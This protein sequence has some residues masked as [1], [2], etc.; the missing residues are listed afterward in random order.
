MKNREVSFQWKPA[1]MQR[2]G[3]SL[4][5][6]LAGAVLLTGIEGL[7]WQCL[8]PQPLLAVPAALLTA[9]GLGAGVLLRWEKRWQR[10]TLCGVLLVL[11]AAGLLCRGQVAASMAALGNLA[12][13]H[14]FLTTGVYTPPYEA[15]G[16]VWLV[17]LPL[18]ALLGFGVGLL[19]RLRRRTVAAAVCGLA[20]VALRA[21]GFLS[22]GWFFACLLL[23]A[24]LFFA[25]PVARGRGKAVAAAL[26]ALT[27]L[28]GIVPEGLSASA[29]TA[30]SGVS[31]LHRWL[32]ETSPNP[33]PEGQISGAAVYEGNS[34]P[35]LRVTMA[36]WTPLYFRGYV[37]GDYVGTGWRQLTPW[38]TEENAAQL[39]TLQSEY[40]FP[41]TQL[42]AASGAATAENR[43]QWQVLG[44]CQASAYV[45][46]GAAGL[47]S[48]LNA[49]DITGEGMTAP[50]ASSYE[51]ALYPVEESYLLQK[52]LSSGG[53]SAAYR[54]GEA[55]YRQ[56]VYDQYLAVP[57]DTYA[58][59]TE[60]FTPTAGGTVAAKAAVLRFLSENITYRE[61]LGALVSQDVAAALVSGGQQGSSVQYAT[62]T[63]LLLRCCG[64]PARYVEGYAVT[65]QQAEALPDGATLTLTQRSAHAWAEYY[66]D[67]VGWLPFDTAPD[68]ADNI[69]YTLPDGGEPSETGKGDALPDREDPPA[70]E[71]PEPE[72][73][74]ESPDGSRVRV[75]IRSVL[76]TVLAALLLLSAA[77]AV[78]TVLLRR[79]WL[80]C[81]RRFADADGAVACQAMLHTLYAYL[82]AVAPDTDWRVASSRRSS[83]LGALLGEAAEELLAQEQEVWFSRHE[84]GASHR[85]QIELLLA[86][87]RRLWQRRTSALQ[88]IQQRF[89]TGKVM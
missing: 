62:L 54:Q 1:K 7:A 76:L 21:T 4:T 56:W 12:A 78:R 32:Y 89:I 82:S 63:A 31:V 8:R 48:V 26:L 46:Y 59:L 80:G 84:I 49:G 14:R 34:D 85:R 81:R 58:A 79:K 53:G 39:Y 36:H 64:V 33:L 19:L 18:G 5:D 88:R 71:K 42:A 15:A 65:R 10:L 20:A 72:P 77:L 74:P 69:V 23:G 61:S 29:A 17:L 52:Q 55:Y 87:T 25:R 86:N 83:A 35:A 9:A 75:F 16:N 3:A 70:E 11:L 13:N 68:Y 73:A 47:E 67:G 38:Q 37:A 41:A 50:S 28:A 44:A 30:G 66:L 2:C 45:P 22:G 51:A 60:R 24:L 57:Q 27:L 40:F 6:V 43:L